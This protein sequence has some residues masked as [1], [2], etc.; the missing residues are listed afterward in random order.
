MG[1]L[2]CTHGHTYGDG[3]LHRRFADRRDAAM[4]NMRAVFAS[5]VIPTAVFHLESGK[6]VEFTDVNIDSIGP[7]GAN[8]GCV[9]VEFE[10]DTDRIVHI[11]FV[12]WWEI[13]YP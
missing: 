2:F 10:D 8:P 6:T 1:C 5:R 11:P 9:S 3:C 13:T 7:S 12:V 4:D